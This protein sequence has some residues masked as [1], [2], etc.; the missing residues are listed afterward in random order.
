[1][2]KIIT[3]NVNSIRT[4]IDQVR[5]IIDKYRPDFICLQETK[6]TNEMFPLKY[7]E[8]LGYSYCYLNGIPSYNGV[9]IISKYEATKVEIIK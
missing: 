6:V 7:F 2:A 9:C 1:M 4:R 3:W 5:T 8:D